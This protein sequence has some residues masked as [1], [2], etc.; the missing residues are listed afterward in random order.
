MTN[1]IK[2]KL[3]PAIFPI[4][5]K[6]L[7]ES[8]FNNI[9]TF[10]VQWGKEFPI[11]DNKGILFVGKAVNGWITN[12]QNVEKLFS[13]ENKEKIF[14]RK[15]QIEWVDK[16]SGNKKGYNPRKSAFWRLIKKVS[17]T[18]YPKEWYSNIAWTNL[19]KI[20]PWSG[21]N[22]S[23]KMQKQQRSY[24]IDILK[25]EI[26]ILKPEYVIMLTSNWE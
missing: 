3:K 24:C 15:E 9:C 7:S 10:A 17:E 5:Q 26:D 2:L 6:L 22:P 19:Y 21:G 1:K 16:L 11:K 25:S 23:L 12:N 20:A 13:K 14:N 4:Y 18:Y 8:E